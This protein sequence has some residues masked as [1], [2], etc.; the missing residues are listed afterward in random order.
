[1]VRVTLVTLGSPGSRAGNSPETLSACHSPE[2]GS[3]PPPAIRIGYQAFSPDAKKSRSARLSARRQCAM[4]IPPLAQPEMPQPRRRAGA[5]PGDPGLTRAR[6]PGAT[7]HA[8]G[9]SRRGAGSPGAGPPWSRRAGGGVADG[10]SR[11]RGRWCATAR[12]PGPRGG[13]S[14]AAAGRTTARA[15]GPPGAPGLGTNRAPAQ[16]PRAGETYRSTNMCSNQDGFPCGTYVCSNNLHV[17]GK[18]WP[19]ASI[20]C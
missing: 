7:P 6:K 12:W 11:G 3:H 13:T 10:A 8:P 14:D 17:S 9:V 15:S 20:R 4:A 19:L 2:S 1:M 18:P 16:P 5:Y